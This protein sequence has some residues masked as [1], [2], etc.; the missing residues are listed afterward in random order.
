MKPMLA[1]PFDE[2]YL[3]PNGFIQPK[4]DGIRMIW[5]GQKALT[6]NGKSID[7]VPE[8]IKSLEHHFNGI[9]LDGELYAHKKGFKSIISS[10]RRS[11][12]IQED[13]DILYHVYD[14]PEGTL[15]FSERFAILQQLVVDA[16]I[17]GFDRLSLVETMPVPKTIDKLNVFEHLNYEG[18]MWRDRDALYAFGKRSSGLM[19]IKSFLDSE[20]EVIG[21]NELLLHEKLI[22][23]AGTPGASQYSDGT[24]YKNG[25]ST[26][27]DTCG[28]LVCVASNGKTFEVGTGLDDQTRKQYWL[29]PPI[30]K[31]ITVKYQ[32]LS[33]DGIPRFPVHIC[34]R[35]YE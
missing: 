34:V 35:D 5:T 17:N 23:P 29:N 25:Q 8:L 27:G 24:W 6:R 13:F 4:L 15:P 7:G 19:K 22:V 31:K 14:Y 33:P 32:E 28:N 1:K 18:T 12:N 26:G 10:V 20:F 11:K 21:V 30:G 2:K 3:K 16:K 9:P